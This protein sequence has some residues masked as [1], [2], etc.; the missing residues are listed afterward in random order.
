MKA[1]FFVFVYDFNSRKLSD[2]IANKYHLRFNIMYLDESHPKEK[3]DAI[4]F[5]TIAGTSLCPFLGAYDEDNGIVDALWSETTEITQETI[6]NFF[7]KHDNSK[8][9]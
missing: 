4:Y 2:F 8:L 6:S 3:K 9:N 7:K 5:K 1:N